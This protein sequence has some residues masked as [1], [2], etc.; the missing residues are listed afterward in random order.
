MVKFGLHASCLILISIALVVYGESSNDVKTETNSRQKNGDISTDNL[1]KIWKRL[2]DNEILTKR[3]L[4]RV[5]QLESRDRIQQAEIRNLKMA[6]NHCSENEVSKRR[7]HRRAPMSHQ[8]VSPRHSPFSFIPV[9]RKVEA[10]EKTQRSK[11]D[12]IQNT[13][14]LELVSAISTY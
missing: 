9:Q 4:D 11:Y 2:E 3:L 14:M 10:S 5:E 1:E 7:I 12:H 6:L 8:D 13:G